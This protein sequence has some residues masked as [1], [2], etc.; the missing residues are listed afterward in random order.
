MHW[1]IIERCLQLHGGYGYINEY[2]VARLW[3]DARVQQRLY[4]G[5][6]EVMRDPMGRA[7]VLAM[8]F[9]TV[10]PRV[11]GITGRFG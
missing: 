5:T 8:S 9:V 6:T 4:A 10:Q 2:E 1:E 3:R 7:M 11:Q